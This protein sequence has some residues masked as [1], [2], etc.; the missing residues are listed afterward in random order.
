MHVRLKKQVADI[1]TKALKIEDFQ[2]LH[3]ML[4]VVVLGGISL[5]G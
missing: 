3:Q 5:R 1:F 2:I 4:G